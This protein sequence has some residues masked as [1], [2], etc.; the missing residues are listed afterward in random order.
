MLLR[1]IFASRVDKK[2]ADQQTAPS[3]CFAR[4]IPIAMGCWAAS[5]SSLRSLPSRVKV[6]RAKR[7]M[8]TLQQT[9]KKSI[10]KCPLSSISLLISISLFFSPHNRTPLSN[11]PFIY[12]SYTEA[13][14]PSQKVYV[15]GVG[16]T[17]FIKPRDLR[18]YP[19]MLSKVQFSHSA[20][21]LHS[22][23]SSAWCATS[24]S[25]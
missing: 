12:I 10:K 19:G 9:L 1:G 15:V 21:S 2:G 23:P 7:S 5:A 20:Y 22:A 3:T 14:A 18:D 17:K 24:M 11:P 4:L 25:L 6:E 8:F 13:M 16:M